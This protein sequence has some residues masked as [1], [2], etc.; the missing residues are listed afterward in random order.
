MAGGAN[1]WCVFAEVFIEYASIENL[2]YVAATALQIEFDAGL[3]PV[4]D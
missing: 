1:E 2:M 4:A 3:H